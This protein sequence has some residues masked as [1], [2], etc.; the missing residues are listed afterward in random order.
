M[1]NIDEIKARINIVELV[2]QTVKL[3]RSGKGY[4]GFC[5]FHDNGSPPRLR[6]FPEVGDV[7]LFRA[8]Q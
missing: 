8:V 2:S 5:P 6:R 3:R 1:N 7:A 4:T